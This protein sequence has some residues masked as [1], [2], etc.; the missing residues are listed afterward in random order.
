VSIV[1]YSADGREVWSYDAPA[2]APGGRAGANSVVWDGR[3][4]DGLTVIDGVYLA[5]IRGG[6]L[7]ATLKI[8]VLK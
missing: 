6:G 2:G 4:G 7:D 8:A 5:R 3:N 1:L